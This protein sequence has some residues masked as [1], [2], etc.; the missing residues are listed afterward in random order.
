MTAFGS[1]RILPSQP[2]LFFMVGV[3]VGGG[4]RWDDER[5]NGG[6]WDVSMRGA[7][8][9]RLS[10]RLDCEGRSEEKRGEGKGRIGG[11]WLKVDS[12]EIIW[13]N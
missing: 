6:R 4:L 2:S 11:T 10:L 5:S 3:L 13:M 8:T 1:T 7:W 12:L 9:P